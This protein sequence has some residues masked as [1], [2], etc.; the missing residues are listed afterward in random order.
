MFRPRRRDLLG[1]AVGLIAGRTSAFGQNL[2][3]NVLIGYLGVDPTA[4]ASWTSAFV[5]RM[6]DLGWVEGRNATYIFRWSQG[7]PEA[8]APIVEEF[9][10]SKVDVMAISGAAA[11]T[12]MRMTADVPIVFLIVNDPLSAGIVTDLAHPGGNVTGM[13]LLAAEIATKRLEL[14]ME[15]APSARHLLVLANSNFAPALVELQEVK[16]AATEMGL[17]VEAV[18]V[19]SIA[20]LASRFVP[21][22]Q[23]ADCVYVV[24]D[25]LLNTVR[26]QIT[27]LIAERLLP[28]IY[29]AREW[30]EAG[31][32]LSYGP[33]F[34]VL[35]RRAAEITDRILRGEKP[36]N[37]PVEQPTRFEL[38]VNRRLVERLGLTVSPRVVVQVD[39]FV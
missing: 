9:L 28:S 1:G 8:Y 30:T 33:V 10:G 24:I 11:P 7:R 12:A 34:P 20:E 27:G 23:A 37:I 3:R 5:Q 15:I 21:A 2:S 14:L 38:V 36:G 25:A 4:W 13:S 6:S 19:G 31:G 26:A 18:T 35:F 39:E 29:G 22:L 32:L 17:F 16:A